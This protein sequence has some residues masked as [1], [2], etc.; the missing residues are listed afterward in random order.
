MDSSTQSNKAGGRG[1][2]TGALVASG[3]AP[4]PPTTPPRSEQDPGAWWDALEAAVAA[5]GVDGID[6]AAVA[7]AGQQHGLVVL[8]A[9]GAVIRP[10]K[11]WNDT[12]S[13]PDA[14]WLLGQ[15]EGGAAAWAAACGSVPVAALTITKLSWLH[16][17]EPEAFARLARVVLPHDWLAWR[18]TG[19]LATDRGDA[20]GTGYF[21]AAENRYRFDLL[22]IVDGERDW[23]AVVPPFLDVGDA[24]GTGDNMAAAL[25][26]GLEAGDV[27]ISLGTSGTVFAASAVPTA[28]PIGA[29]AGYADANGG[30]L[31][32]VCTL[33]ATKVT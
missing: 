25:A 33:N 16:R 11:L 32:L 19:E 15:L 20:S 23:S 14:K 29:V 31:P 1:A 26:L 30:F 10:A 13:A 6:V 17:C 4:H 9:A 3:R 5:S 22:E 24:T 7:V 21:S 8:D 27:V 12:E 18:L 2:D 28:D